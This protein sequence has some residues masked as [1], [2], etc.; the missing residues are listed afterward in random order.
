M[1]SL[2]QE[3]LEKLEAYVS[4][5]SGSHDIE[6]VNQMMALAA[7]DFEGLGMQ[8]ERT[9]L[10]SGATL[11]TCSYGHGPQKLL[12]LGHLDT[13][14]PHEECYPFRVEGDEAY[15]SGVLDMKG[16]V[17]I[18]YFA[19]RQV[20]PKVDPARYTVTCLWNP[21]EEIGSP[22]SHDHILKHG[23]TAFSVLS[24]EPARESGALTCERKGVTSFVVRCTGKRGHA[25]S[26]YLECASAIQELASRITQLYELRD[27]SRNISINI[28]AV[29]GGTVDNI[30]AGE[31]ACWGEFRY[32]DQAYRAEV[33]GRI[34]EIIARPGLPGTTTTLE[35]LSSHPALKA[36]PQSLALVKRAQDIA[37]AMGRTI[38]VESTGGA[39]DI[40]IAGS[41]GTPVVDGLGAEGV[42]CHTAHECLR[43]STIPFRVELV[44][45]LLEELLV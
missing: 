21:D 32:Y 40:S 12:L 4:T 17:L 15:G 5:P 26:A 42:G 35:V 16:G 45:Q 8:V 23:K 34:E 20:L 25:G 39:G 2:K 3:Y 31:A 28:G 29:H 7:R 10:E 14:F 24:F 37:Q 6:D 43:L 44:S 19:L 38:G 41:T 22:G 13:V 11:L 9:E 36:T 27:D 1:L 30:V 18:A 33:L